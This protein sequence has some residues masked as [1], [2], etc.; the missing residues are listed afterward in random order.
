M[1]VLSFRIHWLFS[2]LIVNDN[3][4]Y[5]HFWDWT[6]PIEFVMRALNTL[7]ISGKVLYLGISDAPA[8]IVA[9]ANTIA[10][11]RGWR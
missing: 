8:W 7:V 10:R 11:F 3:S 4:L 1:F 9:Q 6:T 2:K 5:V